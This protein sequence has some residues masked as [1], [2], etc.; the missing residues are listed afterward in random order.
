MKGPLSAAIWSLMLAIWFPSAGTPMPAWAAQAPPVPRQAL[1]VQRV[2]ESVGQ[3]RF[4]GVEFQDTLD[5]GPWR[6]EL[7]DPNLTGILGVFTP[8]YVGEPALVTFRVYPTEDQARRGFEERDFGLQLDTHVGGARGER[9]NEEV[10]GPAPDEKL[11]LRTLKEPELVPADGRVYVFTDVEGILRW[12][13]VIIRLYAVRNSTTPRDPV[14]LDTPQVRADIAKEAQEFSEQ[15]KVSVTRLSQKLYATLDRIQSALDAFPALDRMGDNLVTGSGTQ[16]R[17]LWKVKE[18]QVRVPLGLPVDILASPAPIPGL[19]AVAGPGPGGAGGGRFQ[20]S[21]SFTIE[22]GLELRDLQFIQDTFYGDEEPMPGPPPHRLGELLQWRNHSLVL[23]RE[24]SNGPPE[25]V[26]RIPLVLFGDDPIL[27]TDILKIADAAIPELGERVLDGSE[28]SD[29]KPFAWG[30][31]ALFYPPLIEAPSGS[32]NKYLLEVT[33]TFLV[34]TPRADQ[35]PSHHA[36][37]I[38]VFPLLTV[39]II[40]V[41]GDAAE[42]P[43]FAADLKMVFAPRLTRDDQHRPTTPVDF[44]LPPERWNT[45]VVGV[46]TDTNDADRPT[47]TPP[48]G[49]PNWD[50][51]FDYM[52]PEMTHETAFDAVLYPRTLTNT[53]PFFVFWPG[54]DPPTTAGTPGVLR[55]LRAPGQGEFDNVHIHPYVGFD[56]PANSGA[57]GDRSRALVEAP[58]AA[59]EVIHMHWRWGTAPRDSAHVEEF[60]G[61]SDQGKAHSQLGAPMIPLNQSLRIKVGRNDDNPEASEQLLDPGATAVWYRAMAH[62]AR[63]DPREANLPFQFSENGYGLAYHLDTLEGFTDVTNR[64]LLGAPFPD[65]SYHSFRW[66]STS[67]V[68]LQ[69]APSASDIPELGRNRLI[70]GQAPDKDQLP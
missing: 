47:P 33:Q 45:N 15:L 51:V 35:E 7:I 12:N 31:M 42:L 41:V 2:L 50:I 3:F 21:W 65:I 19:P 9:E 55:V 20:A 26:E 5:D 61:Y 10:S 58:L 36:V 63:V 64:M 24:Q 60:M 46:Y 56:D 44:Y 52:Q 34:S 67:G 32:G 59:D 22:G 8:G 69:R 29:H 4:H 6:V 53:K 48:F 43:S 37:V 54:A 62:R 13:S 39:K 18:E 49:G 23:E 11:I 57:T 1:R 40:P 30:I 17:V 66:K 28:R 70:R 25:V 38:K 68:P 27:Y 14:T 16:N